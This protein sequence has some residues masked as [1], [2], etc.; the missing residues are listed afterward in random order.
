AHQVL[1]SLD[2]V[3]RGRLDLGEPV[4]LG[5]AEVG[6]ELP[7]RTLVLLAQ[8]IDAEQAQLG[9]EDQPLDFDVHTRTVESGFREVV[10]DRRD[11][12]TVP[13]VEWADRLCWH[14]AHRAPHRIPGSICVNSA[15][16]ARS[17][18]SS[19]VL[20]YAASE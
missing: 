10:A 15:W 20:K 12:G 14:R 1:N 9:L 17:I 2:V 5:L 6:G 16:P 18:M 8:R 11:R 7:Q 13:P 19:T 4:D 3:T